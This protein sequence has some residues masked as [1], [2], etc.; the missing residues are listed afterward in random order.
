VDVNGGS[1][2]TKMYTRKTLRRQHIATIMKKNGGK[3]EEEK[4]KKHPYDDKMDRE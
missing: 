3:K 1:R 4:K 2:R